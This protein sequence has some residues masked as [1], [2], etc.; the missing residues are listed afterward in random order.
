MATIKRQHVDDEFDAFSPTGARI[1]ATFEILT[2]EHEVR[3]FVRDGEDIVHEL[4]DDYR[5]N[6]AETV[7]IAGETVYIDAKGDMWKQD[8]LTFR[9]RRTGRVVQR[10]T[11]TSPFSCP[12]LHEALT[13]GVRAEAICHA[14]ALQNHPVP[15]WPQVSTELQLTAAAEAELLHRFIADM[16]LQGPLCVFAA[17]ELAKRPAAFATRSA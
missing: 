14:I 9:A 17:S 4:G 3:F 2:G 7:S 6:D 1:R 11:S 10:G 13:L 15:T 8:A 12:N 5:D 16:G